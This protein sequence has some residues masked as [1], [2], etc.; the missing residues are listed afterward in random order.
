M[1]GSRLSERRPKAKD[2]TVKNAS[3]TIILDALFA[4]H[5]QVTITESAGPLREVSTRIVDLFFF[6]KV[7]SS[8]PAILE[9]HTVTWASVDYEVTSVKEFGQLFD[10][11]RVETERVR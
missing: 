10:R 6:P 11:L 4:T 5:Q 7:G 9:K 3:G 8:F 1:I 2:I